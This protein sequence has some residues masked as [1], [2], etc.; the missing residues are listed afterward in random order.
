MCIVK[1]PKA[2]PTPE[3][4]PAPVA[5]AT[6][7]VAPSTNN[8]SVLTGKKTGRSS[9]SLRRSGAGKTTTSVGMSSASGLGV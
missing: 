5:N 1:K 3:T 8:L 7:I 4:A 6:E 2:T 9:L